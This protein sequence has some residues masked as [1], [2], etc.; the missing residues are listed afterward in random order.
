MNRTFSL[1]NVNDPNGLGASTNGAPSANNN[2]NNINNTNQNPQINSQNIVLP[3]T[4]ASLAMA[5]AAAS[6]TS[7]FNNAF[8]NNSRAFN[9]NN[10][11]DSMM[12]MT[13][14]NNANK[15]NSKY[16]SSQ[17]L[18]DYSSRSPFQQQP[19]QTRTTPRRRTPRNAQEFLAAAGVEPQSFLNKGYYVGSMMN[20]NEFASKSNQQQQSITNQSQNINI[21]TQVNNNLL[22]NP[23]SSSSSSTNGFKNSKEQDQSSFANLKRRNSTHEA[24]SVS[25]ANLNFMNNNFNASNDHDYANSATNNNNESMNKSNAYYRKNH[26]YNKNRS[27]TTAILPSS[28]MSNVNEAHNDGNQSDHQADGSTTSNGSSVP[29]SDSSSS[30]TPVMQTKNPYQQHAPSLGPLMSAVSKLE[31]DA[32]MSPLAKTN[33]MEQRYFN[34]DAED[35]YDDY[36]YL[37]RNLGAEPFTSPLNQIQRKPSNDNN[38]TSNTNVTDYYTDESNSC[39]NDDF[40][41]NMNNNT[42]NNNRNNSDYQ[43]SNSANTSNVSSATK[44]N[45]NFNNSNSNNNN[46]NAS[47][48]PSSNSDYNMQ[49]HNQQKL[50]QTGNGMNV[51]MPVNGNGWDHTSLASTNSLF[52]GLIFILNISKG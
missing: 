14:L 36:E 38:T 21:N 23:S 3:L 37:E 1:N 33:F 45:A 39:H 9:H 35:P 10:T 30:P 5:N 16:A 17:Y 28:L 12:R 49:Q 20:L 11:E 8:V 2:N 27:A 32:H 31:N 50:M 52:S 51:I 7:S 13:L 46:N 29:G 43:S 25:M 22:Q 42:N 19:Q 24:T 18:N 15:F 44:I 40:K 34:G 26:Q 41:Q 6:S 4:Q 47:L 48:G